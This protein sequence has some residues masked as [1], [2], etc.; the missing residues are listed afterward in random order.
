VIAYPT[1]VPVPAVAL[2]G[3]TA[4][5]GAVVPG[6]AGLH[7][8]PPAVAA[9]AFTGRTVSAPTLAA[10]PDARGVTTHLTASEALMH[11]LGITDLRAGN[12]ATHLGGNIHVLRFVATKDG[13]PVGGYAIIVRD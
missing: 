5:L 1:A 8:I 11:H 10:H 12:V 7:A 13:K 9:P 2:P 4:H 6:P 3:G